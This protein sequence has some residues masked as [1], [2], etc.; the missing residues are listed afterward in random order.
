MDLWLAIKRLERRGR[1]AAYVWRTYERIWGRTESTPPLPEAEAEPFGILVVGDTGTGKSTLINRL[2]GEDAA[3]V[4][5]SPKRDRPP[6]VIGYSGKIHGVPVILYE[7]PSLA[8]QSGA[9]PSDVK[10][11]LQLLE[12]SQKV[13]AFICCIAMYET[14]LRGSVVAALEDY[15][16]IGLDWSKTTV[17]LTFADCIP[18][19]KEIRQKTDRV[20]QHFTEQLTQWQS[21]LRKLLVEKLE[22]TG[23]VAEKMKVYPTTGDRD[24]LLSNGQ[25]WLV[26]L[27]NALVKLLPSGAAMDYILES[28]QQSAT[29][30]HKETRASTSSLPAAGSNPVEREDKHIST[31]SLPINSMHISPTPTSTSERQDKVTSAST[32]HSATNT[33]ESRT[34]SVT[35]L[36]DLTQFWQSI[37]GILSRLRKDCPIFGVLVI[38]ETGAGKSTLINNLLGSEVAPVGHTMESKT[39]KVTPH[40]LSVEG[41]PVVVYDTPGLDDTK[42]SEYDEEHLKIMKSLLDRGKIHLV[43]YCWKMIENRLRAGLKRTFEEYSKIGV[44]WKQTVIALTFSDMEKAIDSKLAEKRSCLTEVLIDK[45]G[46]SEDTAKGVKIHPT[47]ADPGEL[48]PN[49]RPWYVPFWLVVQEILIPAAMPHFLDMHKNNI[50]DTTVQSGSN[51]NSQV[52]LIFTAEEEVVKFVKAFAAKTAISEADQDKLTEAISLSPSSSFRKML[53][54]DD[55]THTMT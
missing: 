4:L 8:S 18:V 28:F 36:D 7:S 5:H 22:V 29:G 35:P 20:S 49:G 11:E 40:E 44:P 17:A 25:Q 21:E 41:V 47:T 19:P 15:Q 3:I 27:Q 55:A 54:A 52:Q 34:T 46:L 39:Q 45:A 43:I 51:P 9:K 26:P 53:S 50:R 14:R 32:M 33:T 31:A 10:Q 24:K 38:G 16:S 13:H 23:D 1:M 42:G 6:S 2:I 37:R 30:S 12:K 48:L